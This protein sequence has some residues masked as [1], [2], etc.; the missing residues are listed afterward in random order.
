MFLYQ[1]FALGLDTDKL[2]SWWTD[3]LGYAIEPN[4][5]AE[6]PDQYVRSV[7]RPVIVSVFT[8]QS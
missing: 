5:L 3:L 1:Q 7:S 4:Y 2:H 6:S 8:S